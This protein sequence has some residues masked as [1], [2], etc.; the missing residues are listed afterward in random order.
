VCGQAAKVI[1][2]KGDKP[3]CEARLLSR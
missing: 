1:A 2:T 3:W